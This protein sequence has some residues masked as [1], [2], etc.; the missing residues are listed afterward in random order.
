MKERIKLGLLLV[1]VAVWIALAINPSYR[2]DW[3]LENALV[4]LAVP[5]LVAGYRRMPFSLPSCVMI[6]VFLCLHEIGAH[7]TY[8]EVPYDQWW[9]ALTGH[10]LNAAL[11]WQRNHFDRLL[12]LLFG[13]LITYPMREMLMRLA[14]LRGAW[15]YLLPLAAIM[16][17]SLLYE[18]IE[19]SAA[20]VFGGDLGTAYLG[21]QGD[22][23]DAQKDMACAAVGA[24]AIIL[25]VAAW[26]I[27]GP[28]KNSCCL[29]KTDQ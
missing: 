10:S 11:G 12:H 20:L 4:L 3:L 23:W 26:N 2:Q 21:T 16:A 24:L 13:L 8:S 17:L 1:F 18:L 7:Y 25:L 5:I 19:W 29:V 15:S 9:Q 6:F 28:S 27:W 14:G 22:V